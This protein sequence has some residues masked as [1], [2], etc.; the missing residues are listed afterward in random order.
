MK[1]QCSICM[2]KYDSLEEVTK[3]LVAKHF[4]TQPQKVDD[5]ISVP[6]TLEPL[7]TVNR[8]VVVRNGVEFEGWNLTNVRMS[9]QD[10]GRTLK[11]FTDKEKPDETDT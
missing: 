9:I 6:D 1:Y 2:R 3:H 5:Y 4:T 7:E 8:V 10:N 11:I